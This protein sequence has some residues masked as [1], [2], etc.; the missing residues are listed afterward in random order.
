MYSTFRLE[1]VKK[2]NRTLQIIHKLCIK[3]KVNTTIKYKSIIQICSENCKNQQKKKK[4][5]MKTVAI[6]LFL[7]VFGH[8]IANGQNQKIILNNLPNPALY[9][10]AI[11]NRIRYRR[12]RREYYDLL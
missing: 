1:I 3:L 11:S 8:L 2:F 10:P 5:F 7:N 12:Q 4:K 6:R 9:T